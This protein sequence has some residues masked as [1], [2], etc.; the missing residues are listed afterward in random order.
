[1][2]AWR[3]LLPK[4]LIKLF[5]G[6]YFLFD[7]L[8]S[9][10]G[11]HLIYFEMGHFWFTLFSLLISV[12]CRGLFHHFRFPCMPSAP[13]LLLCSAERKQNHKNIENSN[14]EERD[15]TAARH[16]ARKKKF[17]VI[18]F[19]A[20]FKLLFQSSIL[21][22]SGST[23]NSSYLYSRRLYEFD[24]AFR[25]VASTRFHFVLFAFQMFRVKKF[26]LY[27]LISNVL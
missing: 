3:R 26:V 12:N 25:P 19:A 6:V 9:A 11:V 7:L 2:Q 15:A 27:L 17:C 8:I 18:L 10:S 1:M 4:R 5:V 16:L 21:F 14:L 22:R 13:L 24:E 20:T 23:R